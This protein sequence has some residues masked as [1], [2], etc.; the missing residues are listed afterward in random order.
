MT[1]TEG[2]IRAPRSRGRVMAAVIALTLACAVGVLGSAPANATDARCTA[3]NRIDCGT[4]YNTSGY[5]V[6]IATNFHP[7]YSDVVGTTSGVTATLP[8]NRASDIFK[9]SNGR[10]YD[11]DAVYVPP[12]SCLYM[13]VGPGFG[14]TVDYRNTRS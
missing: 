14:G 5:D 13:K 7:T 11:W 12:R 9:D 10:F 4:I 6:R 1:T 3:S 2:T 8:G